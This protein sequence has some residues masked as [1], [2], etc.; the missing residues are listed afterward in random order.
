M[1]ARH[2]KDYIF[3]DDYERNKDG[4]PWRE[5][6]PVIPLA[7]VDPRIFDLALSFWTAP[8]AYL[9]TG[10]RRL[11]DIVRVRT[12]IDEHGQRLF[13]MAFGGDHPTSCWKGIRGGE[14]DGRVAFFA[15]AFKAYRN[16]R[17]HRESDEYSEQLLDEC[18]VLNHLIRLE[19]SAILRGVSET[20]A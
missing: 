20:R 8:D 13:V 15:A 12:E 9:L 6:P 4:T 2:W 11:E 5:F 16:P 19:D 18:L 17:A 3:E 14:Q 1:S 10:Y 7:L